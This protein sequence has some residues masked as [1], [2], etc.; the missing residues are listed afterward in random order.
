MIQ[1]NCHY[2]NQEI[3]PE[4]LNRSSPCAPQVQD[5]E[6][7]LG[8]ENVLFTLGNCKIQRKRLGNNFIQNKVS[9]EC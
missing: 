7:R 6:I 9:T 2:S 5:L 3:V 1:E 4:R 8:K